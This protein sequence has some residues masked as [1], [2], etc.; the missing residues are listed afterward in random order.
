MCTTKPTGTRLLKSINS[1]HCQVT[2]QKSTALPTCSFDCLAENAMV[3]GISP[4]SFLSTH[5]SSPFYHPFRTETAILAAVAGLPTS[6]IP[7]MAQLSYPHQAWIDC[8]PYPELRSRIILGSCHKPP[9]L[10]C[11]DLW[12][13][14]L[15]LEDSPMLVTSDAPNWQLPRT[16]LERWQMLLKIGLQDLQNMCITSNPPL[17]LTELCAS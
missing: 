3:L 9:L 13:D 15:T 16:F 5:S 10:D 6:L 7:T 11:L 17:M 2:P 14:F 8:I 4:E 12:H 1:L